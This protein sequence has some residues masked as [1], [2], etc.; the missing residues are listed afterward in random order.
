MVHKLQS[1]YCYLNQGSP[2]VDE[3]EPENFSQLPFHYTT[4]CPNSEIA[5]MAYRTNLK[6][7]E[8]QLKSEE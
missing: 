4:H 1:Y 7:R 2:V 3:Q 8:W 5:W 6:I